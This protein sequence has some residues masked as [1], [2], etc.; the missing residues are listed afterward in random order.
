MN[1]DIRQLSLDVIAGGRRA[2]AKAITLLEGTRADQRT[3]AEQLLGFLSPHAGKSL[4]I[5]ISGPPGVGKSTFIEALGKY[6]SSRKLHLAVL[7]VDPSS[8]ISGGS[9][10]GDRVRMEELSKDPLVFIRPSPAGTTLGGVARH[11]RET[12]LACEAGGSD[13]VLIET[14]GV[15]QSETVVASMVDAFIMLYQPNSGDEIQGMKRG[16]LELADLV[17]VT[18]AD[19]PLVKDANLAKSQLELALHISRSESSWTPPVVT[20]SS[21][22][23]RGIAELWQQVIAFADKQ[24]ASGDFSHRRETQAVAW[25][26]DELSELLQERLRNNPQHAAAL[27][28]AEANVRTGREPASLAAARVLDTLINR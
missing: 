1:D 25:F 3:A 7:A 28:A 16:I 6:L 10:L 5:G 13:I 2:L 18:K 21:T 20:I 15:G 11:T 22:E 26:R 8:P 19:G 23:G 12:I 17:A 24:R 14:V 27:S 9:I 4:R